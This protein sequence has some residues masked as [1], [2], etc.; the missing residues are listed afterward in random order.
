MSMNDHAESP[1]EVA[2]QEA[3]DERRL[4]VIRALSDLDLL[5]AYVLLSDHSQVTNVAALPLLLAQIRHRDLPIGR[6]H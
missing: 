6:F 2:L 1:M 4:A 5:R 3:S